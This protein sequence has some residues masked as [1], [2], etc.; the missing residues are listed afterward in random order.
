MIP[1]DSSDKHF[2][3]R[4][5]ETY[6]SA[7]PRLGSVR[8]IIEMGVLKGASIRWLMS[9]FPGARIVG[10]DILPVQP[11]WP[12][13]PRVSYLP[14]D[15][16]DPDS[17][18]SLFAGL[19]C[20][21]DL[22]IDDGSHDPRHQARCLIEGFRSLRHGGLYVLED[23]GTSHPAH[24]AFA[25]QVVATDGHV[26]PTALHVMLALQ[27]MKDAG[28]RMTDAILRDLNHPNYFAAT[29]V[30]E[31]AGNVRAVEVFKRT[32]LPLRCYR[33][34]GADFDYLAWRCRCGVTLMDT[35]DSMT[36]LVWKHAP[37]SGPNPA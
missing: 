7:F 19:E 31:L 15:Q 11:E 27:H 28:Q 2:W 8:L 17:V 23:I 6:V 12:V 14:L 13:S 22:I 20:P 26:A 4:Y 25:G 10:A 16:G 3:H 5:T 33:C 29:E 36:C 37:D 1:D 18:R 9:M 24:G 34:G 21:P 35:A 30:A 32:Q